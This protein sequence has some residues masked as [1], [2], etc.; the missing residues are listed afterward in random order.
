MVEMPELVAEHK[1]DGRSEDTLELP[2][3]GIIGDP[4]RFAR[5]I[6]AARQP[7]RPLVLEHGEI[8]GDWINAVAGFIEP[9]IGQRNVRK[10]THRR[11]RERNSLFPTGG[12]SVEVHGVPGVL[13]RKIEDD[14]AEDALFVRRELGP[15]DFAEILLD[16]R[17][18]LPLPVDE[19]LLI[20]EARPTLRV[21]M[22]GKE[23]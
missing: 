21:G 9:R 23:Q 18:N 6:P 1:D 15:N 22:R 5:F 20:V 4:E 16:A 13:E 17:R 14:L 3:R 12:R 11:N 8:V 7:V 19:R 10:E 2:C